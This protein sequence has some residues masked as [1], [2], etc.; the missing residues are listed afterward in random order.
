MFGQLMRNHIADSYGHNHVKCEFLVYLKSVFE[1]FSN[2][3]ASVCPEN[4]SFVN[5]YVSVFPEVEKINKS[6][7]FWNLCFGWICVR[8][9]KSRKN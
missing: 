4:G 1:C 2:K 5:G 3:C 6:P 8:I 7:F 9:S